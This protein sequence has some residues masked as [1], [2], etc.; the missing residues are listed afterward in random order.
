M[1]YGNYEIKNDTG[2]KVNDLHLQPT[3]ALDVIGVDGVA[4]DDPNA[5]YNVEASGSAEI[6]ITD[7]PIGAGGRC[8]VRLGTPSSAKLPKLRAYWTIDGKLEGAVIENIS[9]RVRQV[10]KG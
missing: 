8:T 6:S 9:K 4:P 5:Q 7:L 2:K 3:E 10:K 1:N